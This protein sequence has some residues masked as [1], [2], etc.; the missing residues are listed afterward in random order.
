MTRID[1]AP[2]TNGWTRV[3]MAD[4]VTSAKNTPGPVTPQKHFADAPTEEFLERPDPDTDEVLEQTLA[5]QRRRSETGNPVSV[6]ALL[7]AAPTLRSNPEGVLDLIYQEIMLREARGEKPALKDYVARFPDYA[8]QLQILFELEE[9]IDPPTFEPTHKL[10]D[11]EKDD[12]GSGAAADMSG[13]ELMDVIGYGGMGVVYKARQRSLNR[14]VALKMMLGGA[15]ARP[16][17]LTRFKVEAAAI[18]R[19]KHPNIVQIIEVGERDHCPFLALE[20]IPGGSLAR[21]LPVQLTYPQIAQLVETIARAIHHAHERGIIHR[22]LKPAN[23]LLDGATDADPPPVHSAPTLLSVP[24][25][26]SNANTVPALDGPPAPPPGKSDPVKL[27]NLVT[28]IPKI[29]D[30]GL[31]K[32]LGDGPDLT[33]T[34]AFLGTPAYSAPEQML[35]RGGSVGPHTDVYAVGAILYELLTGKPPF[36]GISPMDTLEMVRSQEPTPPS[37]VRQQVPRDLEIICLHCLH[38]EPSRRYSSALLLADDLRRF[39][40]GQPIQ[41]RPVGR[42]ERVRMWVKRRPA[43]AALIAVSTLALL[44]ISIGG[45]WSASALRQAAQREAEQRRVAEANFEQAVQAVEEMLAEVGGVDLAQIPQMEPVRHKLLLKARTFFETFLAERGDDPTV[46]QTA[47]RALLHLGDIQSLLDELERAE[48]SYRQA[49][50]L[51]AGSEVTQRQARARAT[52]SLGVL[53]K[54]MDRLPDAEAMLREALQE[55]KELVKEA[56]AGRARLDELAQ[57]HYDL[58]TVLARLPKQRKQAE[59]DYRQAKLILENLTPRTPAHR[60]DTARALNNL[61]MLL[62][63]T[64]AQEAEVCFRQALAIQDGL[65]K[66]LPDVLE[67]RWL[68]ARTHNNLATALWATDRRQLALKSFEEGIDLLRRL[69][70]DFPKVPVYRQELAA[71]HFN[72]GKFHEDGRADEAAAAAFAESLR[73]R[74]QLATDFRDT[75]EHRHKL[76]NVLG[77]YGDMAEK[78]GRLGEAER[79]QREAVTLLERITAGS[80]RPA[81]LSDLGQALSQVALIMRKRSQ[82]QDFAFNLRVL[83]TIGNPWHMLAQEPAR[84]G[85]LLEARMLLDRAVVCQ[86]AAVQGDSKQR[87]YRE[88]LH[89]HYYDLVRVHLLLADHAVAVRAAQKL[90]TFFPDHHADYVLAAEIHARCLP[91]VAADPKLTAAQRQELTDAY[92]AAALKLLRQAVDHGF[93]DAG[94]L[95]STPAYDPLRERPEFRQLLEELRKGKTLIG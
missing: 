67:Y 58:A 66:E 46:R 80:T 27:R 87:S 89:D 74:R 82:G 64:D 39:H 21:Q 84:L 19:L 44:A 75:P 91:L 36:Q 16:D 13:Y 51:L 73:V 10:D 24:V 14:L 45:W 83:G 92:A 29:T 54:R 38:K 5:E 35:G 71:I 3:A 1:R 76:A 81:Y 52:S 7:E 6:E 32:M 34:G 43:A 17:D 70:L 61:G 93:R 33:K 12:A 48:K 63:A 26:L 65:S 50:E 42:I 18:A 59:S 9:A 40:D 69:T 57:A 56:G 41:A 90:P 72:L 68:L 25:V 11:D 22:D 4:D 88:R 60:R 55:R 28:A 62:V 20:Y 49:R 94:E 15:H 47:G 8:G 77:Q 23:I 85:G 37:R 86:E 78:R 53:L 2:S 30:F 79:Y 31:A 95:Q